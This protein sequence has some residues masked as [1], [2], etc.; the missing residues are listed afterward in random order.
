MSIPNV[1]EMFNIYNITI[2]FNR[3]GMSR[4][5]LWFSSSKEEERQNKAI[6]LSKTLRNGGWDE[7][8]VEHGL[9]EILAGL[10]T[11][12]NL[13]KSVG[14]DYSYSTRLVESSYCD[15]GFGVDRSIRYLTQ[16]DPRVFELRIQIYCDYYEILI[17][18]ENDEEML[19]SEL[20]LLD[21][22]IDISCICN[23]ANN[24]A[25]GFGLKLPKNNGKP[26]LKY[27]DFDE[28]EII[29]VPAI[30]RPSEKKFHGWSNGLIASNR[31]RDS[32]RF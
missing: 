14:F 12:N 15:I 22:T 27:T 8:K 20:S 17:F 5:M 11:G 29:H 28:C 30:S 18:D 13:P 7:D 23:G 31:F 25:D 16:R 6:E 26:F 9:L 10:F 3:Y 1:T 24:V 21:L 19:Y 4:I 2:S 32:S